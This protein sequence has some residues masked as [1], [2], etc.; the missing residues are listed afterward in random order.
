VLGSIGVGGAQVLRVSTILSG[1]IPLVELLLGVRAPG[2]GFIPRG[3]KLHLSENQ[4]NEII[5]LLREA[6]AIIEPSTQ[7]SPRQAGPIP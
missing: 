2:G 7:R 6:V 1:G 4:A 5:A 3:P